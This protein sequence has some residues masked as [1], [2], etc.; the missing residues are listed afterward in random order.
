MYGI[1]LELVF[2]SLN[3]LSFIYD[4]TSN[5]NALRF[6][7]RNFNGTTRVSRS[8][9]LVDQKL[10]SGKKFNQGFTLNLSISIFFYI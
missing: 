9:S 1:R 7:L 8:H 5:R 4:L 2:F 10:D 3:C 6:L